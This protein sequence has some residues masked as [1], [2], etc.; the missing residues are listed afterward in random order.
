[1]ARKA[2]RLIKEEAYF[3]SNFTGND[4]PELRRLAAYIQDDV[5]SLYPYWETMRLTRLFVHAAR[6]PV[7]LGPLI[8]K[9]I[10]SQVDGYEIEP[11][12]FVC[13]DRVDTC[14]EI[15]EEWIHSVRY[16]VT[17]KIPI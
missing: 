16:C 5:R 4:T 17:M 14:L 3:E 7:V 11:M 1:V 13:K 2:L 12:F 6:H 15:Y 10:H 8:R 9:S